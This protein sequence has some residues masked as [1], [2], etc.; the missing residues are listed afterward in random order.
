M[1]GKHRSGPNVRAA[2]RL[3]GAADRR[4][5]YQWLGVGAVT[6]GLGVAL[7]GA[8]ATAHASETDSGGSSVGSSTDGSLS[9]GQ[10]ATDKPLAQKKPSAHKAQSDVPG[11]PSGTPHPRSR[12]TGASSRSV[13]AAAATHPQASIAPA[14]A[15]TQSMV[16]SLAE[17]APTAAA[18]ASLGTHLAATVRDL[19]VMFFN[20]SPTATPRQATPVVGGLITGTAGA[21]DSDGDPL[22]VK[23]VT[24]PAKGTVVVNTDGTYTYKPSQQFSVAGGTDTFTIAVSETNSAEHVHGL[25]GLLA[26]VLPAITFGAV[27]INDGST[28]QK[29][30]TV[31]VVKVNGA[32]GTTGSAA[33]GTTGSAAGSAGAG[34][35]TLVPYPS[36]YPKGESWESGPIRTTPL[37]D[38][39]SGPAGSAPNPDLWVPDTLWQ[40]GTQDYRTDPTHISL[41]G[42]GH[43]A[44]TVTNTPGRTPTPYVSGHVQAA[45]K[46]SMGYGLLEV[47]AKLPSSGPGLVPAIW[48]LGVPYPNS[49]EY[50]LVETVTGF[51]VDKVYTHYVPHNA[52]G[53]L[54]GAEAITTVT[55]DTASAYHTYWI[56]REPNHVQMGVDD[57]ITMDLTPET[58]RNAP[59]EEFEYPMY[60]IMNLA[61]NQWGGNP[62]AST[63]FPASMY[64]DWVRYTPLTA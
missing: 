29:S 63:D 60:L 26:D 24:G 58:V 3:K 1:A 21:A 44:I 55:P 12:G 31:T 64:I 14:S 39:F 4:K 10:S 25:Q 41:D 43:L 57:I 27:R 45:T 34:A 47:S 2:S 40:G 30:V 19:Q 20:A 11:S 7:A 56:N 36:W 13:D 46:W 16:R 49:M 18:G 52:A 22:A 9:K 8:T 17:R 5:P 51:G 32:G 35:G 15:S 42:N 53:L 50:D 38:D 61:V 54:E 48:T 6:F 62:T 59:W 33:G 23:L 37:F 28:I